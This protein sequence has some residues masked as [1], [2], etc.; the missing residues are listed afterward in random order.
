[1][2]FQ[3]CL[4]KVKADNRLPTKLEK[5]EKI[6]RIKS[7]VKADKLAANHNQTLVRA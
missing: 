3:K 1:M 4:I 7:K 5:K 6:M 2:F